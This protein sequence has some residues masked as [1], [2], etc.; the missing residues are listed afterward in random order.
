MSC[1]TCGR[2]PENGVQTHFLGCG[3]GSQR[4]TLRPQQP[5]LQAAVIEPWPT[6]A[7]APEVR[8]VAQA[9]LEKVG[10]EQ[11]GRLFGALDDLIWSEHEPYRHMPTAQREAWRT[12]VEAE[13]LGGGVVPEDRCAKDGCTNERAPQGRGPRPRYCTDHRMKRS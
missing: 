2:E 6:A 9:I 1:K 7:D 8:R 13:L 3:R 11:M 5:V 4:M 12:A 10:T